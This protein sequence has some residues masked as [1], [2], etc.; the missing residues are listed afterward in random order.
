MTATTTA[1]A[2]TATSTKRAARPP[3]PAK[4]VKAPPATHPCACGC[5]ALSKGSY[6]PG[7]DAR[8]VSQLVARVVAGDLTEMAAVKQ[9]K[10]DALRSKLTKSVGIHKARADAKAA[11]AK[12]AAKAKTE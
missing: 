3:S 6:R 9:L 12:A 7:H 1:P 4:A 8:H 5:G 10:S 11:K 2:K